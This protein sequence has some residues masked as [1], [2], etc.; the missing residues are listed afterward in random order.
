[1]VRRKDTLRVACKD[2]EQDLVF[3]YYGECDGNDRNRVK[4]HLEACAS[5]RQF[6]EDLGTLLPL[7]VK[8]DEPPQAFW[9]GYSREMRRKLMAVQERASWWKGL[10]TLFHPWSVPALATALVLILALGLTFTKGRWR[11]QDLPSD[12]EALQEVLPM[13]ENLEFFKSLDFIELMDLLE[14][15]EGTASG[16]E[17]V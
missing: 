17:T 1:M 15:V 12:E 7:T 6:L 16:R 14:A 3:Y 11:S 4:T 8:P 5:C 10:F 13:A 9:E 2:F